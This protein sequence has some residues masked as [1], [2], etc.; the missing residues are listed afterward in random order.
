MR[1][2]RSNQYSLYSLLLDFHPELKELN[3]GE[4]YKDCQV[5]FIFDGLDESR[6]TLDLEQKI[7]CEFTLDPN[8]AHRE[9]LLSEGNRKVTGVKK[10]QPYP[11]HL[12]RFTGCAQVLSREPLPGRCYWECCRRVG[13]YVDREVGTLSFYRVSSDTLTH[14]HTFT[15]TF[16]IHLHTRE[17]T[18]DPNTVNRYLRLSEGNRKVT[19]AGEKQ[20]YPDHPDRFTG[21]FFAGL[22]TC[23]QVLS[24]EPLPGRCYWEWEWSGR[25]VYVGVA[26][27]TMSRREFIGYSAK[28][29]C[30][31]CC[32]DQYEAYHNS[33]RTVPP[34]TPADS[35]RVGVYVDREVGTLSFYRVSSDT[36]THL[37][38]FTSTFT[39]EPL[40]AA[41]YV[42][43]DSSVS[44]I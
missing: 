4:G 5:V 32:S 42:Y 30:L 21:N 40:H 14:L 28:A 12:D 1:F 44:L 8:T 9:L 18:L 22:I 16:T 2:G 43:P 19:H 24:R 11:D 41:I 6:M 27:T 34:V 31:Y 25:G 33:N 39:S 37:H 20:P 29:W 35:R 13:V 7:S 23:P 38:T 10:A 3:D 15:T 17:F 26:Y 36:L